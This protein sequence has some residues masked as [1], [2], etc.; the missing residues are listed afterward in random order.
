MMLGVLSDEPL[1]GSEKFRCLAGRNRLSGASRYFATSGLDL[2]EDQFV[3][4]EHDQ[5]ELTGGAVPIAGD[6]TVSEAFKERLSQTLAVPPEL[7][8]SRIM[9]HGVAAGRGA[10]VRSWSDGG[11]MGRIRR[12]PGG[13]TARRT[14]CAGRIRIADPAYRAI[15]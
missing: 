13:A 3:S 1:R 8:G 7:S 11:R 2:D 5:V 10:P 15:P 14:L 12:W 4:I 9:G 6:E